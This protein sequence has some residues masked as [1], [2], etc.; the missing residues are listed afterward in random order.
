[1]ILIERQCTGDGYLEPMVVADSG[2]TRGEE[3]VAMSAIGVEEDCCESEDEED[4]DDGLSYSS[5]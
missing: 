1:M 2:M 4:D 5:K 3:S